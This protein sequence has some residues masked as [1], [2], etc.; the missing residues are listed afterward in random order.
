MRR[1]RLSHCPRGGQAENADEWPSAAEV[2]AFDNIDESEDFGEDERGAEAA[3]GIS[4]AGRL[5]ACRDV[6]R[7]NADDNAVLESLDHGFKL[8]FIGG[9][10]PEDRH[11]GARN[12]I[13]D[14]D[15]AWV[16][17]AVGDLVESGAA[18]TW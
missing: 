7:R 16:R 13:A 18:M 1:C 4:V 10:S 17:K 12:F 15:M 5:K 2:D 3:P 9:K 11:D 8:P 14:E 6:W